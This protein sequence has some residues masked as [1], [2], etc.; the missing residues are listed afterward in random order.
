[1]HEIDLGSSTFIN[2]DIRFFNL[3]YLVDQLG[4]FD[5]VQIDPPWRIKG[6]QRN[7]TSFMFSNNKFN[8][9]YSTMSNSEIMNI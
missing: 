3:Q 1:M 2:C 7:N 6:A 4:H 8:L 5:I 9:D